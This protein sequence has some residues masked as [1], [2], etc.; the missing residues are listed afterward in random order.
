MPDL[1][2]VMLLT[3]KRI[4]RSTSELDRWRRRALGL[5]LCLPSTTLFWRAWGR[6]GDSAS[7]LRGCLQLLAPDDGWLHGSLR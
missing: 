7:S 5:S 6:D 1:G 2:M 4:I 3:R